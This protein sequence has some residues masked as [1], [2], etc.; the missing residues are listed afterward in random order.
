MK[1]SQTMPIT[2]EKYPCIHKAAGELRTAIGLS[3]PIKKVYH[4]IKK[5]YGHTENQ[6]LIV[7]RVLSTLTEQEFEE[8]LDAGAYGEKEYL[9]LANEKKIGDRG[10]GFKLAHRILSHFTYDPC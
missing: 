4:G 9:E 10:L 6:L 7:E 2:H 1:K 3:N 8:F 5:K